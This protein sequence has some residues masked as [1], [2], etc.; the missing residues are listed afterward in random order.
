VT[1]ADGRNV[2]I[3][4]TVPVLNEEHCLER[5]I[6][7]LALYLS[8]RCPYDWLITV[9]D[10]GSQDAT[11]LI[12]DSMAASISRVRALRLDRRGRGAALKQAWTTS[13]AD[14]M[15]YMD[16]DLSTGLHALPRLIEPIVD[17][18]ADVSIGSRL[19][20][21][22]TIQRSV[23]REIISRTY[24]ILTRSA[25]NYQIRD[26]QCGFKAV[27]SEVA[28]KLIPEIEDNDWFFD[29]E[30]LV[31]ASRNGFV[32]NEV[33]VRWIEDS[34][35]RVRIARTAFADLQGI[36]RLRRHA[37]A[38]MRSPSTEPRAESLPDARWEANNPDE[39]GATAEFDL[40]AT[41]YEKSVDQAISFTGRDS[42][43]F[44]ERKADLLE[45]LA[46]RHIGDLRRLHVLDV[47]CGTGTTCR[48]L[49]GRAGHLCGVDISKEMLAVARETVQG[50]EF[51]WYDG[52]R[53]PFSDG[54]FDVTIAI[55]ALHHVPRPRRPDFVSEMNRVTRQD[56]LIVIF[57]H[58]PLN[59]FT[60]WAVRSC[61]LDLNQA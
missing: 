38:P 41:R 40:Y 44:A 61:E 17:G 31:L 5:S 27:S 42:D 13:T 32:I 53:L 24:N 46:H 51:R 23:K 6:K 4:I 1:G 36:R 56:G 18:L 58:N 28:R 59:P 34:D 30:L 49:A 39:L 25:F 52:D 43:F 37:P 60:R 11:G 8:E 29:T 21:G 35:S 10:S 55:C 2:V 47:G 45:E 20:K 48:H 57:E 16:V 26:A 9:V 50:A 15:A 14:V 12:A 33:P 22:A 54:T 19:A 7:T 3:D